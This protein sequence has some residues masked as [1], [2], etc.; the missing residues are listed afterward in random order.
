MNNKGELLMGSVLLIA[1]IAL[2]V[3]AV[4]KM[5]DKKDLKPVPVEET[6]INTLKNVE[7]SVS[8]LVIKKLDSQLNE[9][10]KEISKSLNDRLLAI[11]EVD[12]TETH[13]KIAANKSEIDT[14]KKE[15]NY[16]KFESAIREL[17]ERI[18]K[19]S[20]AQSKFPDMI[21]VSVKEL[22]EKKD[23]DKVTVL[24]SRKTSRNTIVR[25]KKVIPKKV[26]K[27][28][29][30]MFKKRNPKAETIRHAGVVR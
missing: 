24:V 11:G 26:L 8:S 14:L 12:L 1:A 2:A 23:T 5:M 29:E 27:R 10:F 9:R 6:T 25:Y 15:R 22:R 4:S 18:N 28:W 20:K 16:S 13:N 17:D 7:D 3:L 21:E 30:R 19:L